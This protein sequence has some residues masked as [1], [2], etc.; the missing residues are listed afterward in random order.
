MNQSV[1][2]GLKGIGRAVI[3]A[4]IALVLAL[5]VFA[6]TAFA[7]IVST[8]NVEICV[9]GNAFVITTNETEPI[10]ILSQANVKLTQDD[11][12]DISSF[13]AGEG[14]TIAVDKL[15]TVNIEFDDTIKA[16]KVY[17]DTVEQAIDELGLSVNEKSGLSFSPDERIIDGMVIDISSAKSVTLNADGKRTKYAIA[18]GTVADLIEL[19]QITLG[20]ED[21]TVPSLNAK[22]KPDMTVK[23]CRVEYREATKTETVEYKTTKKKNSDL[24][25][26]IE[27]VVK[28]GTNGKAEVTYK[29]KYVNGK[30]VS[31]TVIDSV[32]TKKPKNMVVEVGSKKT[33][34]NNK[35]TPN[36]VKSRNGYKV[37]QE[38]KGRYTHYCA[39]G[40]C[41]SGTGVTASGK[42]VRN[43]MDN[44]YYIACNWLPIGSVVNIDGDNYTVVD[45]GGSGLSSVG[46]VDIF[47]P[48][49]HRACFRYG[50]GSCDLTIVRIGW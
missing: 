25:K 23:V 4:V 41:G 3:T 28:K 11:K 15:K 2:G 31:K 20:E 6:T 49:G 40:T 14:G 32:V 13:R 33:G 46:R 21:Y 39:C 48:E 36:G 1:A 30:A 5:A 50:T 43:G 42:R 34:G 18:S 47:T 9:D 16:Y 10:E 19:A 17:A 26:G 7:Q 24:Y 29:V 38:I 27:N 35:I 45:R 8:Y 44:P 37:G 22:L 12:L